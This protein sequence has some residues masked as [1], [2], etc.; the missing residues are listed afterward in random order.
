MQETTIK[1]D[2]PYAEA[3]MKGGPVLFG[4]MVVS[5]LFDD[6]WFLLFLLLMVV[7]LVMLLSPV[8]RPRPR[9]VV[10]ESAAI[11]GK[12]LSVPRSVT[13]AVRR[14]PGAGRIE[15]I[16]SDGAPVA[17]A[18]VGKHA[19]AVADA[20]AAHGWPLVATSESSQ[21]G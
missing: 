18:D 3:V 12:R 2:R 4:A 21:R 15:F 13:H 9:A 6:S 5:K 11:L 10:S 16:D 1:L 8:L 17:T 7:G 19:A 20:L 14:V